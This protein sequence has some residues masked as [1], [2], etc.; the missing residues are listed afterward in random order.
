MGFIKTF[1]P[2]KDIH[3]LNLTQNEDEF[4]ACRFSPAAAIV[5]QWAQS[6]WSFFVFLSPVVWLN[7]TFCFFISPV[8]A[9]IMWEIWVSVR[10]L[11]SRGPPPSPAPCSGD[12]SS[13]SEPFPISFV[14]AGSSTSSAAP[15]PCTACGSSQ[16]YRVEL[17]PVQRRAALQSLSFSFLCFYTFSPLFL[18]SVPVFLLVWSLMVALQ[19]WCPGLSFSSVFGKICTNW[20]VKCFRQRSFTLIL[21]N[22]QIGV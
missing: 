20:G 1:W 4:D 15:A 14:H 8:L 18:S 10:C 16:L 12:G 6:L 3:D 17:Q 5:S 9:V 19:Q 22:R 7:I 11:P 13:H 21:T 2:F